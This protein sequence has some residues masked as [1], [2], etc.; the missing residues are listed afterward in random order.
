M[1]RWTNSKGKI[2]TGQTAAVPAPEDKSPVIV[3]YIEHKTLALTM[4]L[5]GTAP[6][7][8]ANTAPQSVAFSATI[9]S[10]TANPLASWLYDM[11]VTSSGDVAVTF[12]NIALA[13]GVLTADAVFPVDVTAGQIGKI[14][15]SSGPKTAVLEIAVTA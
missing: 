13:G 7:E 15:V 11:R 4:A 14:T 8:A 6:S 12:A 2:F 9:S 1:D 10:D 3:D 5:V